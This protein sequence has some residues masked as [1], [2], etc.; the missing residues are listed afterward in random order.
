VRIRYANGVV[1]TA[2]TSRDVATDA[3]GNR[4]SR[5]NWSA[6]APG[7]ETW[8]I[9]EGAGRRDFSRSGDAIYAD[10][11]GAAGNWAGSGAAALSDFGVLRTNGQTWFHCVGG[12]W[13]VTGQAMRGTVDIEVRSAVIPRPGSISGAPALYVPTAARAGGLWSA[14]LVSGELFVTDSLCG[15]NS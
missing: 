12:R 9:G 13:Q 5:A 3:R 1:V 15:T 2:N 8:S 7:L 14:R 11:R 4:L 6:V 10:P